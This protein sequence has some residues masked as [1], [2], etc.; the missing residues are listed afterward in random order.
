MGLI[1]EA[2]LLLIIW[3][4]IGIVAA[5]HIHKDMKKRRNVQKGW[6]AAGLILSIIGFAAYRLRLIMTRRYPYQYPPRPQYGSPQYRLDEHKNEG[7]PEKEAPLSPPAEVC[8]TA[9]NESI[10][11]I[12]RCPHCGAAISLHDWD[13]PHCRAP[14]RR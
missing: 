3:F 4:G 11:G 10:E 7:S 5:V 9:R 2:V 1:L 14:L 6:I 8:G 13:C 12:P